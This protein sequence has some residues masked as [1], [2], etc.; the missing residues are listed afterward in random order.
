MAGAAA[1]GMQGVP[2]W[3]MEL[4]LVGIASA[5]FG[6][7]FAIIPLFAQNTIPATVRNAIILT[8]GGGTNEVQRDI[9]A[10]AG[11]GLPRAGR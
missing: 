7:A 9:I 6:F 4:L 3:M 5:R 10:T 2:G 11:L 1:G 8:F